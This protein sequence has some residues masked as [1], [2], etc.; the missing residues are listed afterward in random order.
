MGRNGKDPVPF[1][2]PAGT[3]LIGQPFSI[4]SVGVPMNLTLT[5]NCGA[6]DARPVLT[7]N[8]SAPVACPHCQK[9]YNAFFNPQNGQIQMLVGLPEAEQVPS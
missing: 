6:V 2:A 3:P 8:L 7:V 9:V 5:C 1:Q 4:L